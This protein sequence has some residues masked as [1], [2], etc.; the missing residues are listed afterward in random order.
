MGRSVITIVAVVILLLGVTAAHSQNREAYERAYQLFQ[1]NNYQQA[2]AA[3][4]L[5]LGDDPDNP[6]LLYD[7]GLCHHYLKQYQQADLYFTQLLDHT[8]YQFQAIYQLALNDWQQGYYGAAEIGLMQVVYQSNDPDLVELATIRYAELLDAMPQSTRAEPFWLGGM[9]LGVGVDDNIV[10]S[11]FLDSSNQEDSFIDFSA[12][13]ARQWLSADGRPTWNWQGLLTANRYAEIESVDLTVL[14]TGIEK[15]IYNGTWQYGLGV[16]YER[17]QSGGENYLSQVAFN[18]QA[19][20]N[21]ISSNEGWQ[22]DY[23]YADTKSLN[24]DFD[25]LAGSSHRATVE[26]RL[27][28]ADNFSWWWMLEWSDEGR[29]TVRVS[30]NA[31]TDFSATREGF[32]TGFITWVQNWRIELSLDVRDSHYQNIL[33]LNAGG[34]I[35]RND[36]RRRFILRADYNLSQNWSLYAEALDID[37][38]SNIPRFDYQQQTFTAGVLWY[39]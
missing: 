2:L 12:N 8:D 38:S 24:S 27:A 3:F 30:P 10:D 7:V 11:R 36:D 18:L 39:F 29:D 1:Q 15:Y 28:I 20:S 32:G 22:I 23:Q 33:R 16:E 13:L 6:A 4:E 25:Q 19:L 37:N 21:F 26:Y 14:A 5:L 9:G 17:S 31:R 35:D 34:S